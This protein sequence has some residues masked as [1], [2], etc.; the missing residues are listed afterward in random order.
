[1]KTAVRTAHVLA[2]TPAI[3]SGKILTFMAFFSPSTQDVTSIRP[4][5]FLSKSFPIDHS[6]FIQQ[7]VYKVQNTDSTANPHTPNIHLHSSK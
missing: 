1:V 5:L 4:Q 7:F 2:K 3:L 6:H